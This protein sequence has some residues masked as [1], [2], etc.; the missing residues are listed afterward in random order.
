MYEIISHNPE[1]ARRFAS[2]MKA[3]TEGTGYSPKYVAEGFPWS[4][5]GAGTV[6]DVSC[7]TSFQH[8]AL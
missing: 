4:E 2:S 6:V 5:L 1:R 8:S 7:S 3:F